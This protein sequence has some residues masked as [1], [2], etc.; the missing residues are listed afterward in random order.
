M[1]PTREMVNCPE[2]GPTSEAVEA[3]TVTVTLAAG[4]GYTVGSPSGAT[5]TITSDEVPLPTVTVSAS[6][7][8]AAENP[9]SSGAF[10]VSRTGSTAA[11]LSVSLSV[12]GT[13]T[14]GSDYAAI[15]TSLSIPA[16]SSSATITVTPVDDSEAEASESV[17]VTLAAATAY[18]VGSPSSA[19]V[20]IS[21]DDAVGYALWTRSDTGQAALWKIRP[22]D[23]TLTSSVYLYLAGG[24]GAPWKATSYFPV[25]AT[26]GYVLWTR[27]DTGQA[28]LW[29]VDPGTGALLGSVYL[30]SQ[31]GVGGPWQATS[32]DHVDATTGYVLW[33]RSDTGQAALWQVNPSAGTVTKSV[34]LWTAAGVGAPWQATGFQTTAGSGA[35]SPAASA[36][37]ASPGR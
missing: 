35:A 19:T 29:K 4:A 36:A 25:D 13:A 3:E 1:G 5:V 24:V 21:D 11:S 32:Y 7:A 8:T 37:A 15:G 23:G 30:M 17:T 10:T 28:A 14:S 33:T 9:V 18:T 22:G 31:T 6:D 34:Y 26:T 20:A 16:G 12:G 2:V 27:K